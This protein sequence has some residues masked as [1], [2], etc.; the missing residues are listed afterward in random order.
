MQALS[1]SLRCPCGCAKFDH[2]AFRPVTPRTFSDAPTPKPDGSPNAPLPIK[3]WLALWEAGWSAEKIANAWSTSQRPLTAER[4]QA[5]LDEASL[6]PYPAP[7]DQTQLQRRLGHKPDVTVADFQRLA[8]GQGWT[9]DWLTKQLRSHL[10]DS[11]RIAQ[12]LLTGTGRQRPF[13]EHYDPQIECD[14]PASVIPYSCVLELYESTADREQAQPGE[15]A[16]VCSCGKRVHGKQKYATQACRQRVYE[17]ARR[18]PER[19]NGAA[20]G[21]ARSVRKSKIANP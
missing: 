6:E 19:A 13:T 9:E 14:L 7:S 3:S 18:T 8:K 15:R 4:V 20:T 12:E 11:R 1:M 2:D 21:A 17:S 10:D 5:A 16:C